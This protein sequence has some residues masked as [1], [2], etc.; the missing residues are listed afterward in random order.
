MDPPRE[1]VD[2]YF[3]L[4]DD[5]RKSEEILGLLEKENDYTQA[6]TKHLE[7][8]RGAL[9]DEMLSH[10]KEDDETYPSPARDGFS[11]WSRTVKGKPFRQYFRQRTS[12]VASAP[13]E[14]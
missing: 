3:W 5:T 4:R 2:D 10:L 8:F 1:R 7:T 11:Y 6:K 12:R 14:G 13:A 9:Y